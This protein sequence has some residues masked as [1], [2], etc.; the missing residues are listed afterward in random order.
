[1]QCPDGEWDL[2]TIALRFVPDVRPDLVHD[3]VESRLILH[4]EANL[5]EDGRIGEVL[6]KDFHHG[7]G[8][9]PG[10]SLRS[11]RERIFYRV[12]RSAVLKADLEPDAMRLS[13][14]GEVCY[15]RTDDRLVGEIVDDVVIVAQPDRSPVHFDDLGTAT[16]L[17]DQPI[18][19][20]EGPTDL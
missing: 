5:V 12:R 3:V 9:D 6:E 17:D 13:R 2:Q 4:E 8:K 11:P 18:P 14:I 7:C 19:N 15:R 16:V 20:S 10:G 1:M